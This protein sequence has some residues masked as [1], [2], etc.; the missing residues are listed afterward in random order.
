M[1][2]VILLDTST[3]TLLIAQRSK[4]QPCFWVDVH[5]WPCLACVTTHLLVSPPH[6]RDHVWR[7]NNNFLAAAHNLNAKH[8]SSHATSREK[9]HQLKAKLEKKIRKDKQKAVVCDQRLW[10]HFLSRGCLL[11]ASLVHIFINLFWKDRNKGTTLPFDT[12]W[13]GRLK[14]S[15]HPC[16]W[17]LRLQK[18]QT[19][20]YFWTSSSK[21]W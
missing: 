8:V 4:C 6:P 7:H 2:E 14:Q 19:P 18:V 9:G 12:K 5:L 3:V 15:S 21:M 13:V 1:L 17:S 10:N 11:V 20:C 16:L